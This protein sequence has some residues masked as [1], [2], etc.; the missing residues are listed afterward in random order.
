MFLR[1]RQWIEPL[2]D[3]CRGVDVAQLRR[4]AQQVREHLLAVGR[5]GLGSFNRALFRPV[6]YRE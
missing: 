4:D 2:P 5:E 1:V 3:E 6:R